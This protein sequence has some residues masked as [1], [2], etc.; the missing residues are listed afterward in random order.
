[1]TELLSELSIG[2]KNKATM[3]RAETHSGSLA[4]EEFG[5]WRDASAASEE[6]D[7]GAVPAM[8]LS[9]S[10]RAARLQEMALSDFV[11]TAN[12]PKE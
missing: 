7:G 9:A 8:P 4:V 12:S 2:G 10:R 5:S 11:A 3:G 1:M 6:G